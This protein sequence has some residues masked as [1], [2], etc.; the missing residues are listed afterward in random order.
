VSVDLAAISSA[1]ARLEADRWIYRGDA[2]SQG[3]QVF[4]LETR[5]W[6]R[7]AN[8]H[9]VERDGAQ[10]RNYLNFRDLLRRSVDARDRYEAIKLKLADQDPMDRRAYTKGKSKAEHRGKTAGELGNGS[11]A[12]I[13]TVRGR[14]LGTQ[15]TGVQ[16]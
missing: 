15:T 10:W 7:V 5:P 9:V 1:T 8:L 16:R 13:R 3:G 12:G 4:V 2:G 14:P 11:T 6:H